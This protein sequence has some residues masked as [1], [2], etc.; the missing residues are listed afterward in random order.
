MDAADRPLPRELFVVNEMPSGQI[1]TH[2]KPVKRV[3]DRRTGQLVGSVYE[4]N[5]GERCI[6]WTCGKRTDVILT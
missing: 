4:W 1:R 2:A 5:N 3:L 6:V